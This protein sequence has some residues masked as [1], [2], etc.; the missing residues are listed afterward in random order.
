MRSLKIFLDIITGMSLGIEF[1]TGDD[2]E[3]GDKFV[4]QIDVLIL[5][6]TFIFR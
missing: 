6:F 1:F 3:V 2:L 5:R 4:V